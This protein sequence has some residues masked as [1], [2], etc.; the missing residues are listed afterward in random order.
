MR[1]KIGKL[2]LIEHSIGTNFF[3][4]SFRENGRDGIGGAVGSILAGASSVSQQRTV[5]V[6]IR[7]NEIN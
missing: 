2:I 6:L 1:K 3:G 4:F 5:Y 7:R